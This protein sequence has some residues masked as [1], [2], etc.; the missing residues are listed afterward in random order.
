MEARCAKGG[1]MKET[2]AQ[3][4]KRLKRM[5][6]ETWRIGPA[7]TEQE[8]A[9][10]NALLRAEREAAAERAEQ[11]FRQRPF[12]AKAQHSIGLRA[13]ILGRKP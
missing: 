10:L 8:R 6:F 4:L 3:R 2:K 13:A 7:S 9:I 11:W 12:V 1:E 5:F